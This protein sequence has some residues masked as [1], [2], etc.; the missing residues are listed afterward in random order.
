MTSHL[1]KFINSLNKRAL[2]LNKLRGLIV[3]QF[4]LQTSRPIDE[5]IDVALLGDEF[6]LNQQ[7]EAFD[8]YASKLLEASIMACSVSNDLQGIQ[9]VQMAV[10]QLKILLPEIVYSARLLCSFPLSPEV[11]K[12]MLAYK[13]AWLKE[14][15]LLLLAVDDIVNINDYLAVCEN[16]ILED[17]NRCI[18]AMRQQSHAALDESSSS[19]ISRTNRVCDL[20][21]AEM[22]N[23]EPC[24]F[25][26]D[27]MASAFLLKT[28]VIKN[29]ARSAEY[30][31]NALK[32]VPVKDPHEN[33]FIDASRLI[34]DGVRD[35]RNA[36]YFLGN[37]QEAA[38]DSDLENE[39]E[40]KESILTYLYGKSVML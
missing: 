26:R 18:I 11:F 10:M 29:F 35:V 22:N 5:L 34:Y 19:I 30:A 14:T 8:N 24:D 4:T 37:D 39:D 33:D 15:D 40:G 16:H 1:N 31:S 25:T 27:V 32:A 2:N 13:A 36:L 20:V 12:N 38:D 21:N 6:K 28:E 7:I 3:E 23:Y 17:I 9:M